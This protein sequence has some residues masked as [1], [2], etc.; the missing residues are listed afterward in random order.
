MITNFVK[1]ENRNQVTKTEIKTDV[2]HILHEHGWEFTAEIIDSGNLGRYYIYYVGKK[3]G[4]SKQRIDGSDIPS[5]IQGIFSQ[6]YHTEF[7]VTPDKQFSSMKS[8]KEKYMLHC[9]INNSAVIDDLCDFALQKNPLLFEYIQQYLSEKM[10]LKYR[11]LVAQN[12]FDL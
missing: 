10:K 9:I 6:L 12:K 5:I 1:Y 4:L 8:P 2:D 11:N 7:G 3:N